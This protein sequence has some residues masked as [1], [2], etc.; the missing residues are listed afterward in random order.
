MG[1][2]KQS[3][4]LD[5]AKVLKLEPV[6]GAL[7]P[8]GPIGALDFTIVGT[9]F[10]TRELELACARV[11]HFYIDESAQEVT[12][13]LPVSKND[14]EVFGT[15]RTRGCIYGTS[16]EVGCPYHAAHRQ[17]ARARSC[18]G[19]AGGVETSFLF[20]PTLEGGRASK[21]SVVSMIEALVTQCGLPIRD[22]L[23]RPLYGGHSLRSGG[24]V[25]LESLGLGTTRIE[26]M[27]NG[28]VELTHAS[29]LHPVVAIEVHCSSG[30][31][32]PNGY[33]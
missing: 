7:V 5:I 33:K 8:G 1:P 28:Q 10:P 29:I 21:A 6:E 17:L 27:L 25:L 16:T 13:N 15:H 2:S 11:G 20:F 32:T 3:L 14:V 22:A 31:Q 19:A 12:W 18:C 23:D 9:F 30:R 26:A 4:P 24:A